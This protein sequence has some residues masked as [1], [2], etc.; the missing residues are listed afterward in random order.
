VD[1]Q[2]EEQTSTSIDLVVKFPVAGSATDTEYQIILDPD[3]IV[4][5][6][7]LT[8]GLSLEGLISNPLYS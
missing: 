3:V 5:E 7:Q 6:G 4:E 2:T 8:T 1:V